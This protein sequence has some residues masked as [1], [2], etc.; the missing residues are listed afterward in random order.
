M[1]LS[2]KRDN[3]LYRTLLKII[4]PV[5]I[6]RIKLIDLRALYKGYIVPISR[7][8]AIWIL[9]LGLLNKPEKR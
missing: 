2:L 3:S 5:R 6:Y 7:Y 8:K 1:R 4:G 9:F